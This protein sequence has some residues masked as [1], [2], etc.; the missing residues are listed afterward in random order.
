MRRGWILLIVSLV[1]APAAMRAQMHPAAAPFHA[2][3]LEVLQR[4]AALRTGI[5]VARE[6]VTT[7][8]S[9]ARK[10]YEQG[11]AY[12]HSFVWIEAARS[13]HTAL[14]ADPN[15]ALAHLGLSVA[16]GG[17]GSLEGAR[18][19]LGIAQSLAAAAGERDRLRIR[20]RGQQLDA[21][22]TGDESAAAAYRTAL[23]RALVTF[24]NDVELLLLRGQSHDDAGGSAMTS[25]A[26]ST[27]FY[28]RALAVAPEQFAAHHYLIHA[29]ENSGRVEAAL[30]Q[31]ELYVRMVPAVPH[32]HHMYGHGLRRSGRPLEA[33]AAFRKAESLEQAYFT[34][35]QIKPQ[36]DWHYHHNQL[37]LAAAYRSVGQ[38][39]AARERLQ[40]EFNLRA[41]LVAEEIGKRAWPAFLIATGLPQEALS[42]A[43]RLI[44][45][46]SPLL[47]ATGHLVAAQAQMAAHR[48]DAA[49]AAADAALRELKAAGPGAAALAT[50]L[51]LVQGEFF[52]R[53][54]ERDRGLLMIRRGVADLR[55]QAGP[56]AWS[57][58]TFALE[59]LSRIAR[60][61]S[62][63]PLAS[64]LAGEMRQHDPLYPG[65]H[66]AI[67]RAA[68]AGGDRRAAAAGYAR[69]VRGWQAA[70]A[71]LVDLADARRR[72][73][74]LKLP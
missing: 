40:R 27:A 20:L 11:L 69:A 50:D 33:L 53:S 54:G 22:V 28:E 19:E 2:I 56:D 59:A 21:I 73:A 5:G 18:Q 26:E 12:L 39:S 13:F 6:P 51:R 9:A 57:D 30:Q 64:E 3:S 47:R 43:T 36:D 65:T 4:P 71:D 49:G 16:F 44:A 67:G 72:L 8:S 55:S 45:H 35:E 10:M 62:D 52:L 60:D 38:M 42:A 34:S 15:L 48:L 17:L 29:Y 25:G 74:A 66:Y 32:A 1:F 46:Q 14:A 37:L 41:P 7:T 23:D 58:T 31:A 61:I 68:E 24:P 63:W 70:D